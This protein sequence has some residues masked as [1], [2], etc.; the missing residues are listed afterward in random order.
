MAAPFLCCSFDVFIVPCKSRGYFCN[1][2]SFDFAINFCIYI[3]PWSFLH[4]SISR[5]TCR[6]LEWSSSSK[7][8]GLLS[9]QRSLFGRL[10]LSKQV[11]PI[12]IC[13]HIQRLLK[14]CCFRA[15]LS[16]KLLQFLLILIGALYVNFL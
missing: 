4:K 13:Q 8:E 9:R 12:Q 1:I 10:V 5:I 6:N 15:R 7:Q 11:L 14:R 2:I 16:W 3:K